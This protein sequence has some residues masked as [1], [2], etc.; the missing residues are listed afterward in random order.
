MLSRAIVLCMAVVSRGMLLPSAAVAAGETRSRPQV[1]VAPPPS[2]TS[3]ALEPDDP[4]SPRSEV[5]TAVAD[6][7]LL[8]PA[9]KACSVFAP[10]NG[11]IGY[12]WSSRL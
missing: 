11:W 3:D 9:V 7:E 1:Q 12:D 8:R 6:V 5:V 2:T 10:D 4:P